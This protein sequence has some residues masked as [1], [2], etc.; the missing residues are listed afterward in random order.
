M[1]KKWREVAQDER[2]QSL[3][4]DERAAAREEYFNSVIA[5]QVPQQ[6]HEVARTEFFD[7]TDL[8]VDPNNMVER[9]GKGLFRGFTAKTVA[10]IPESAAILTAGAKKHVKD[11]AVEIDAIIP[12]SQKRLQRFMQYVDENPNLSEEELTQVLT[13]N[14]RGI[15]PMELSIAREYIVDRKLS[16]E[17]EEILAGRRGRAAENLAQSIT[18]RDEFMASPEADPTTYDLYQV[19]QDIRQYVDEVAPLSQADN[20]KLDTQVADAFGQIGGF[21]AT[22][23]V[24]ALARVPRMATTTGL[25][26]SMGT[27]EAFEDAR[28]SGA[29]LEQQL[30][31]AGYGIVPGATESLPIERLFNVIGGG[32]ASTLFKRVLGEAGSRMARQGAEEAAQEIS[33]T[34]MQNLIA[35]DLVEYDPDRNVFTG[36]TEAGTVAFTAGAL[37]DGA[38]QL[39]T[40]RRGQVERQKQRIRDKVTP[41][42][43]GTVE[44]GEAVQVS[45]EADV[46]LEQFL[47]GEPSQEEL[48]AR[49]PQP[50]ELKQVLE[51]SDRDVV[52]ILAERDGYQLIKEDDADGGRIWYDPDT[53]TF[54]PYDPETGGFADDISLDE[55][56]ERTLENTGTKSSPVTVE[57]PIDTIIAGGQVDTNPT[58]EQKAAGN[59]KKGHIKMQGLDIT[60]ENPVGSTRSGKSQS[61]EEWSVTMP[62]DYGYIKRTEGADGDHLDVYIGTEPTSD[63]VFIVDQVDPD[64]GKFDEHKVMIGFPGS[65]AALDAY[66]GAF[67]DGSASRRI[68]SINDMTVAEF[69]TWLKDGD[70]AKPFGK[71]ETQ[72][73]EVVDRQE[74]VE[75]QVPEAPAQTVQQPTVPE[76]PQ[77]LPQ[78]AQTPAW[79]EDKTY[80][81]WINKRQSLRRKKNWTEEDHAIMRDVTTRIGRHRA[82][83]PKKERRTGDDILHFI[84]DRG[85]VQDLGGDIA[86]M[87]GNDWHKG[88]KFVRKLINDK[89]ITLDDM[90]LAAWESGYFHN[91]ADATG[92]RPSINDFLLLV[93]NALGG[94][95][96]NTLDKTL[97]DYEASQDVNNADPDRELYDVTSRATELGMPSDANY[98]MDDMLEFIA[99]R[100][101]IMSEADYEGFVDTIEQRMKEEELYDIPF[102]T[103]STP[104]VAGPTSSPSATDQQSQNAATETPKSQAVPEDAPE[105]RQQSQQ[106]TEKTE[107][108]EQAVVPGAERIS[109]KELA[110]RKMQGRKKSEKPQKDAG[111][112]GGLFDTGA[113]AQVD[114]FGDSNKKADRTTKESLPVQKDRPIAAPKQPADTVEDFGEKIGG[115]RKDI[116]KK[117]AMEASDLAEIGDRELAT[118][119]KKDRIF[120]K[121]DYEAMSD[122]F[123]RKLTERLGAKEYQEVKMKIR[124]FGTQDFTPGEV[125]AYAIKTVRDSI[126]KPVNGWNREKMEAYVAGVSA[127]RQTLERVDSLKDLE[128]IITK[129][130]GDDIVIESGYRKRLNRESEGYAQLAALGN[131]FLEAAQISS[132]DLGQFAYKVANTAF[133]RKREAWENTYAIVQ[134]KDLH[135]TTG[136]RRDEKGDWVDAAH[137][138]SNGRVIGE[139]DTKEE[140]QAHK[141][142]ILD[143][144]FL[145]NKKTRTSRDDYEVFD[146]KEEAVKVAK[147][148]QKTKTARGK[149]RITRPQ[150][151]RINRTGL[152]DYRN[153]QDVTGEQFMDTFRFRGGEFGN[154]NTAE[155]RQQSLN[156]AYDALMDLASTLNVPPRALSLGGKLGIAFGA[157]GQSKA[158]AHYEPGKVVINLT[159]MRGAGALAH[160]WAHAMDDYFGRQAMKGSEFSS[161]REDYASF[162]L[163]KGKGVR[164]EVVD[165]WNDVSDA[166]LK[167]TVGKEEAM[168]EINKKLKKNRDYAA[169]WLRDPKKS[170]DTKATAAQKKQWDG[171]VAD[172]MEA[173]GAAIYDTKKRSA[174]GARTY[175]GVEALKALHKEVLGRTIPKRNVDGLIPNLAQ[176]DLTLQ[177]REKAMAGELSSKTNSS[178][179]NEAKELDNNS[180]GKAYWA[181]K[182]EMYARAFESYIAD[183]LKNAGARSQYL[184][185][186]VE[187]TE[188]NSQFGKMYP[189]GD[190]R[191]S[192][193]KAFDKMFEVMET[194][195][196]DAGETIMFSRPAGMKESFLK[197]SKVK[198]EVYHG[199]DSNF[200]EFVIDDR[201]PAAWFAKDKNLARSFGET[202]TKH[203]LKLKNPYVIEDAGLHHE[204]LYDPAEIQQL[205]DDGHDGVLIRSDGRE[206]YA[207]F[208]PDQI[209]PV[210]AGISY[211]RGEAT[212]DML[213]GDGYYWRPRRHV[214]AKKGAIEELVISEARKKFGRDVKVVLTEKLADGT[215]EPVGGF[216]KV[217][218]GTKLIAIAMDSDQVNPLS[219]LH[220]EGIHLLRRV[221][222]ISPQEWRRLSSR[223]K[224][225]WIDRYNIRERYEGHLKGYP[226]DVREAWIIEEAIAEA[227]AEYAT[228]DDSNAGA[229]S[230]FFAKIREF[231]ADLA[232]AV[233]RKFGWETW[234]DIFD[235]IEAG[236]KDT[237]G[238]MPKGWQPTMY[239]RPNKAEKKAARRQALKDGG[240]TVSRWA[241]RNF[242]KEGLLNK[243]TFERKIAMEGL[244]N[245][246]ELDIEAM[247]FDFEK[248]VA[249]A[250]GKPY[251]KLSDADKRTLKDYLAGEDV[252]V[253]EALKDRI[254]HMRGYLDMASARMQ[255][256]FGDLMEV[257]LS[258]LSDKQRQ[259]A[260]KYI[261]T[262]GE[263]GSMP[264]HLLKLLRMTETIESNKG[265]YL[266]RSYQA[267]D[268]PEW[269]E[270]TLKDKRII[271]Q[272]EAFIAEQNPKLS[273]EEVTGAVR[274]IL[275]SAKDNGN[276]SSFISNS[277]KVGSKDVTILKRRKEVPVEIREL[278]G[279]YQDPKVAFVR[280]AAKMANYLSGHYF[281]TSLY[282]HGLNTFMYQKPTGV[283][284][285][286]IAS[287]GN[288]AMNPLSGLYATEDFV[289]GM[290]D[291]AGK[292]EG[293]HLMRQL[294]GL[295]SMVKYGKT[296]LSPTTQFRNFM[297]AS[298]FTIMN[299]HYDWTHV[300]KAFNATKS[301]LF[302][303]QEKWRSYIRELVSL[304]VLHN[305]PRSQEL[306]EAIQDVVEADFLSTRSPVHKVARVVQKLYQAGDDF[307]KIIGF[308]NEKQNLMKHYGMTEKE[309]SK[310]A[311][312]RIRNGYPTYSMI[313]RAVQKVRIW[314]VIGTFV[315]F[316]WEIGRTSANQVRFMNED[317]KQ[318]KKALAAQRA[319]GMALVVASSYAISQLS[320]MMMGID[321]DD[322]EAIRALAPEWQH[323]SQLA[324]LG[325]DKNGHPIYLDL[326]HLDPYT[327]LKKPITALMNDNNPTS[328]KKVLDALKEMLSPFI[329]VDIAAGTLGEILYNKK[330]TGGPVYNTEDTTWRQALDIAKHLKNLAPGVVSNIERTVKAINEDVSRSGRQY[331]LRDEGLAWVGFRLTTLNVAQSIIYRSLDFSD[332]RRTAVS[333]L[334]RAAGG[335]DNVSDKDLKE[336][337]DRMN[338][339]YTRAFRDM[340]RLAKSAKKLGISDQDL[341]RIIN[342]GGVSAKDAVAIVNGQVPPWMP[343]SRFVDN[344]KKRAYYSAASDERRKE[345]METFEKRVSK[346]GQYAAEAYQ[347]R[348]DK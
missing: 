76:Q 331:S 73:Q 302:T 330:D 342:A 90:V 26:M 35:S 3:G 322:D 114:L 159:K 329:G 263:E 266:H 253:P 160:E 291:A 30:E 45:P 230:S 313:P 92:T 337:F 245:A 184:V 224:S 112:D 211:S 44:V 318:G 150:L 149:N 101:A 21:V 240:N 148:N 56:A 14:Q 303:N 85:G 9:I 63:Q 156:F 157:R 126:Q 212:V 89:G 124:S 103:T 72:K 293:S 310:K 208:S 166:I 183:K 37:F 334:S 23:G 314:P 6:D 189:E 50:G 271:D 107:A 219:V 276:F 20:E 113:R 200:A 74:Q 214:E 338:Q 305:N 118:V 248:D 234:D 11:A 138:Y 18:E 316:P 346:I 201:A 216:F 231:L 289:Q 88:K 277:A 261:D 269:K 24:G 43:E 141:D 336:A 40:G 58:D 290:E 153:G 250:Y 225:V 333:I 258:K 164:D 178:F 332:R 246:Y 238:S 205:K 104:E 87:G 4:N 217:E 182:H 86:S 341:M 59:Y 163:R 8:D 68:G 136:K 235:K 325:Y 19:G 28:A 177:S 80:S 286:K 83:R 264:E 327:Y 228:G 162:G 273:P 144:F 75:A 71:I 251:G 255:D 312:Y 242:T 292:F 15:A 343:S 143:K 36:T 223:A 95:K 241:R 304:G 61:G 82:T 172:M 29:T 64:T 207:V 220:H 254:A 227:Y 281:L 335:Q 297:S 49:Q 256:A 215:G 175:K 347:N 105:G 323:N 100:E 131:K 33:Q 173:S 198:H 259:N 209:R 206:T 53:E 32:R 187:N 265:Q 171:I 122:D 62:A 70:N 229:F 260:E 140:G 315:S 284:D 25:G 46:P 99:E 243:A 193:N 340:I 27:S 158:A 134:G 179:M 111:S 221:G 326:S 199:T 165:A 34:M 128:T 296:V 236:E 311:A 195:T 285:T 319:S 287:P 272:A 328:G 115:A 210:D 12:Q 69:K 280:S 91:D 194:K 317:W 139:F 204:Y 106:V 16:P 48:P 294:I 31:A 257:G 300:A 309:A 348:K 283:F 278:L 130:F 109:D 169:S 324:Y 222:V 168:G 226:E 267:F 81:Q 279:E 137:L 152:E 133:P 268:D 17:N 321:E 147:E 38:L 203:N 94:K 270:K 2:F 320:M 298:M 78:E 186:S 22:G 190:E 185:H 282:H 102:D 60:I 51:E 110:E 202:V 232:D 127:V 213:K 108:G 97:Q 41:T 5:P 47:K 301:D 249:K 10:P 67:N 96:V 57:N 120:P 196:D 121:P 65:Q 1:V 274:A 247:V 154:W 54:R 170:F 288:E 52:D 119:V 98:G 7:S 145:I 181:T 191:K 142:T 132:Y 188:A 239:Q 93:E 161:K 176:L 84:S 135:V 262:N 66:S 174:L 180:G 197:D 299:G 244:K 151:A 39:F 192:I 116:W 155:D 55:V 146:S 13:D 252:K 117:R 345:I 306:K 218:D 233:R 42:E 167:R 237:T 275:Q 344:A 295:N 339:G 77:Q 129:T 123:D 308:E 79:G 307:W 125:M